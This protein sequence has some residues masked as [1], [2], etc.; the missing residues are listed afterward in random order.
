MERNAGRWP[1]RSKT[2]TTTMRAAWLHS[3]VPV[4]SYRKMLHKP[5]LCT[6]L[7]EQ[8]CWNMGIVLSCSIGALLLHR[9]SDEKWSWRGLGCRTTAHAL[10]TS[11]W[12]KAHLASSSDV[13]KWDNKHIDG[14]C[15]TKSYVHDCDVELA[16][17]QASDERGLWRTLQ[18][19]A[20]HGHRG[21][22]DVRK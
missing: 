7:T 3:T 20:H 1:S 18:W 21:R 11:G 19:L 13:T 17:L 9:K 12:G 16:Q 6:L 2:I 8:S 5:V 15:G 4:R 14:S 10:R 22:R